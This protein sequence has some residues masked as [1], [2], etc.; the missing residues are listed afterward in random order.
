MNVLCWG[1]P[2]GTP[3]ELIKSCAAQ[4]GHRVRHAGVGTAFDIA[5][6]AEESAAAL[7]E[8][9]ADDF[10][11]DLMVCWCPEVVPPPPGIEDAPVKTVAVV[12][13]WTVYYPQLE[14]N[15][16][17]YDLVAA[18]RRGAATLHLPGVRT[19]Y[20]GPLY[21][22]R[23]GLH[24]NLG[25]VR[26]IDIA[27]AGNLNHAVHTRRGRLL[28]QVAALASS[29]S[30]AIASGLDDAAYVQLLNRTKIAFNCSL[31]GEMNLR[32]FEAMACGALLFLEEDNLEVRELLDPENDCV[33]YD[34]S[35]LADRLRA[36][37]SRPEE[38][39]RRAR[40]GER[41]AAALAGDRRMDALVELWADMPGNGRAFQRFPEEIRLLA[42]VFQYASS[43]D[44]AHQ[45][46]IHDCIAAGRSTHP[47]VLAFE[48]AAA[49]TTLERIM[50]MPWADRRAAL[51]ALRAQFL[52]CAEAAPDAAP[53]WMN[54]AFLARLGNAPAAEKAFL[55]RALRAD[56]TAYGGFL[57][58]ARRDPYYA[59]WREAMP[60]HTADI[61]LL[62]AAAHA[63]LAQLSLESQDFATAALHAEESIALAPEMALPW[64]ALAAAHTARKEHEAAVHALERGLPHAPFDADCRAALIKAYRSL[65]REAEARRVAAE[66]AVIFSAWWGAA[67]AVARF[68][69]LAAPP[70]SA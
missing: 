6:A 40:N 18:D 56:T 39:A 69:A 11:A 22:Q 34:E 19:H 57:L 51:P 58:G 10:P 67:H 31:R 37:L 55:V 28:E 36:M 41:R 14:Y 15:L 66:S 42:E 35:N 30:V 33:L 9:I 64:Q 38:L 3:G 54:L 5:C 47:H 44:P 52:A 20:F 12:S 16:A 24:R 63:R 59:R 2:F 43:E 32:C 61:A 21:S 45:R 53:L 62:H 65:G 70:T 29:H 27:F 4:R 48:V 23:I 13:D 49:V 25:L 26:D 50:R 17:R 1:L 46:R 8:R 60:S 68:H 7:L